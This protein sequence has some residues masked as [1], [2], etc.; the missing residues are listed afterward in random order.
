[1]NKTINDLKITN[2]LL[3]QEA[4]RRGWKVDIFDSTRYSC[5]AILHAKKDGKEFFYSSTLTPLTSACG[6]LI[7]GDKYATFE[8]LK[9]ANISTPD[10]LLIPGDATDLSAAEAFL[11]KHRRIIIKPTC[12]NHGDGITLN[13]TT[14]NQL[15][16]AI[17]FARKAS[18]SQG[19]SNAVL[20]QEQVEGQE[21]RFLVV[22]GKC[23]AVANRRP[24]FIIGDGKKTIKAL[25]E[26]KNQ[27]P[28]RGDAHDKPLTKINLKEVA[29]TN[30]ADFLDII[31]K[32]GEE[33][34]VLKTSNLSRGGEAINCTDIASTKL[35]KLAEAAAARC[36]LGIAGV[37]IMTTDICGNGKNYI[38]GVNSGP[39]I[40]MHVYPSVGKT[41]DVAKHIIDALERHARPIAQAPRTII[42][43]SE[44][45]QSPF[46]GDGIKVPARTDTGAHSASIWA[47]DISMNKNGK[48]HFRLFNKQS[49]FYTGEV[50]ETDEYHISIV[51]NSTGQEEM[52]FRVKIPITLAGRSINASFTLSDRSINSYPILIGRNVING[53][54]IVDTAQNNCKLNK[55]STGKAISDANNAALVDDPYEFYKKHAHKIIGT[56]NGRQ[57]QK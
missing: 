17:D 56:K 50:H 27:N 25:I 7:A 41:I 52:R 30:G 12:T 49:E 14:K 4:E 3:S 39:G 29:Q 18:I 22:D 42:G 38:T 33:I 15:K 45:I 51:R 54:F 32:Q 31:P 24:A 13:I 9:S 34:E 55:K 20:A 48:L 8:L 11:S 23:I 46:F 28:L 16:N 5:Q 21:Y 10:S 6:Y 26:E 47:S 43:R 2:R 19:D 36:Q 1:M 44:Y 40:R 53:K 37:D 57:E 35:K